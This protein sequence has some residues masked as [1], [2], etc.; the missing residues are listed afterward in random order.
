MDK[1]KL[2]LIIRD[3]KSLVATLE[4]EVYSDVRSYTTSE[5]EYD[6]EQM[7]YADQIEE[8]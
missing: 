4:S 8:L 2:K 3:M 7:T 1:Q 6:R 5:M